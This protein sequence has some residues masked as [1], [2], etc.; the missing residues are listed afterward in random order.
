MFAYSWPTRHSG[1]RPLTR[2]RVLCV[3]L[4]G[5]LVA[6]PPAIARA[7]MA[8]TGT[9]EASLSF[10]RALT[11]A[12][13]RAASVVAR[14]A[15]LASARFEQIA[16]GQLPD[17]RLTLGIDN[18]PVSGP[19]AYTLT[20][21]FMTMRR[22]GVMQDVP[23][24][25]KR[26][27]QGEL[28]QAR[29]DREQAMLHVENLT[30]KREAAVAWLA[31]YYATRRLDAFAKVE[32]ENHILLDTANARVSNGQLTPPDVLTAR[33]EA[34]LLA[35]RHDELDR[36]VRKARAALQRWVGPIAQ[37][38]LA[39]AP[40]AW[41][42]SAEL[43]RAQV[44]HHAELA[45]YPPMKRMAMAESQEAQAAQRGDWGWELVYSKRGRTFGDMVSFQFSFDLPFWQGSR[46]IPK[47]QAR[48]M[49][50]ASVEAQERD[51]RRRHEAETES[52]LAELAAIERTHDRLVHLGLPLARQRADLMLASYQAGRA[53]LGSV[54]SARRDLAEQGLRAIDLQ[55]QS[56]ALHAQLTYVSDDDKD[57]S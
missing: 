12:Q 7:Q 33:Q 45:V 48:Q 13:E 55:A 3:S 57:P 40:P 15:S 1:F 39:G 52:Q 28:A 56:A 26:L 18:L 2:A 24:A 30:V 53:D 14:E 22:M 27:A 29:T 31:L 32:Y 47:A 54:I 19:D 36:D 21:D 34:V 17:P 11:L 49:D 5:L 10:D 43:A 44:A 42:Q 4:C 50:L 23:N 8:P 25:A 16:A 41:A 46:Q 51:M 20:R 37:A 6:L 9:A 35:D 38:P